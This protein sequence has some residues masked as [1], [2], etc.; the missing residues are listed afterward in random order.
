MSKSK[1]AKSVFNLSF[2]RFAK[3]Y[4]NISVNSQMT[5]NMSRVQVNI[6][7]FGQYYTAF[8]ANYALKVLST[9]V[10]FVF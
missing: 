7:A 8:P 5:T 9:N 4:S 6:D 1:F 3:N 2:V 10:W